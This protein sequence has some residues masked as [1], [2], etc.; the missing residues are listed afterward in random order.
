MMNVEIMWKE[1]YKDDNKLPSIG[2][3]MIEFW[4]YDEGS[5]RP[6]RVSANFIYSFKQNGQDRILR[7]VPDSERTV[8][9]IL[10]E[11]DF[12]NHLRKQGLPI[13]EPL[14]S[15]K[16]EEI[17]SGKNENGLFHAV[18]YDRA[19]G[20]NIEFEDLNEKQWLECGR[21][22]ARLHNASLKFKPYPKR[23]RRTWKDDI[24]IDIQKLPE[25]DVEL[26]KILL[27]LQKLIEKIPKGEFYG[28]IH[29]DLCYD[30]IIWN[31]DSYVIIDLD[32]AA[33]YPFAADIAFGID[34]VRE[35]PPE[36]GEQILNWFSTGYKEI[37]QLPA[38]WKEQLNL[39][40]DLEDS[41]KY[42]RTLHAYH[43][44]DPDQ[45]PE[46]LVK[47]KQR[48]IKYMKGNKEK[49]IA[50]WNEIL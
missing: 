40:Y 20:R 8:K 11:L 29:Y 21:M 25:D 44:T 12:M 15:K 46:W 24:N 27:H 32:D 14:L 48:H 28:L 43:G 34:D 22:M 45:Y 35:Q 18:A 19:P 17:E 36:K 37:K 6:W 4:D 30:N 33:Y 7:I 49:L 13:L 16:N 31:S 23:K 41:L 26:K 47:L 50:K 1:G 38:D 3:Q 2:T 5:L 10:A 9:Q 39:F 42:A